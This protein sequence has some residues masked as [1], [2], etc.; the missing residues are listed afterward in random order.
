MKKME[1]MKTIQLIVFGILAV[2]AIVV[3]VAGN[4]RNIRL[5]MLYSSDPSQ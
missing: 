5:A 1:L 2:V 3:V 4:G